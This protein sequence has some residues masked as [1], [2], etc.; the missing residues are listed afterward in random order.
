MDTPFPNAHKITYFQM[1]LLLEAL[2]LAVAIV[3]TSA[4]AID[5]YQQQLD[6]LLDVG[7]HD[8]HIDTRVLDENTDDADVDDT[9]K[10]MDERAWD[11]LFNDVDMEKKNADVFDDNTED[12]VV[13]MG[14]R[15]RCNLCGSLRNTDV[16]NADFPVY[17]DDVETYG[18][19]LDEDLDDLNIDMDERTANEDEEVYGVDTED[20]GVDMGQRHRCNRC[21]VMLDTDVDNADI[22]GNNVDDTR[23]LDHLYGTD[24]EDANMDER[25]AI[26]DGEVDDVYTEDEEVDMGERERC[27]LCGSLRNVDDFIADIGDNDVDA[28]AR[29]LDEKLNDLDMEDDIDIADIDNNDA[30]GLD[31]DLDDINVDN[32]DMDE[33]TAKEDEEVDDVDNAVSR[34]RC[35]R[36]F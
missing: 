36:C 5:F 29:A 34:R 14:A 21:G 10:Y 13:N 16:N 24:V 9:E 22:N 15:E 7:V 35:N 1:K 19:L 25:T 3:L 23:G 6:D 18:R 12:I 32:A 4:R 30:R 8:G 11:Q 28:D 26:E 33:R 27:N 20:V 17:D 2:T 31:A